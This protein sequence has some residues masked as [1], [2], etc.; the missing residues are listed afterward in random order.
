[1]EKP[2]VS[3]FTCIATDAVRVGVWAAQLN[4]EATAAK[5]D[6]TNKQAVRATDHFQRFS[7]S[8]K[9]YTGG[10]ALESNEYHEG[11]CARTDY[12]Q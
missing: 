10:R 2:T 8:T 12:L 9:S 7:N 6:A 11:T 3:G 5:Q 1:V 4:T